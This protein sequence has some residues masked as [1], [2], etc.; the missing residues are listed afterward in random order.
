VLTVTIAIMGQNHLLI[1]INCAHQAII[2]RRIKMQMELQLRIQHEIT[3]LSDVNLEKSEKTKEEKYQQIVQI[4][5]KDTIAQVILQ[6]HVQL[7]IIAY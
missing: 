2:V 7:V 6:F 1:Q 3:Y 5:Q 4:V